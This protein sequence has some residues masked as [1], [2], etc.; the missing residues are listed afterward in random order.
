MIGLECVAAIEATCSNIRWARAQRID[1]VAGSRREA[2]V[3]CR[4]EYLRVHL[5]IAASIWPDERELFAN[6]LC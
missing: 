2:D 6:W 5:F 1:H 4:S 3:S